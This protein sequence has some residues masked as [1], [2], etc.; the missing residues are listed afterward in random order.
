MDIVN[1]SQYNSNEFFKLLGLYIQQCRANLKLS[2]DELSVKTQ[3]S[4]GIIEQ[5]ELGQHTL[6]DDELMILVETM[7]LD[8]S[9]IL[10]L[11]KITQVQNII[12]VSR[13]LNANFPQ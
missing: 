5:I 10:N 6:T 2:V 3:V 8:E 9:E 4:P 12:E 11:A 7:L 13:V 1:L